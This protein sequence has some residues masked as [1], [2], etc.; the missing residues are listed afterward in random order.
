VSLKRV[1][2]LQPELLPLVF[3]EDQIAATSA[4]WSSIN[5][6]I[7]SLPVVSAFELSPIASTEISLQRLDTFLKAYTLAKALGLSEF[8]DPDKYQR[9]H[10]DPKT[11][12]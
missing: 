1:T 12:I 10:Y 2:V 4:V 7:E 5:T 3:T 6:S 8:T 11:Q 9:L